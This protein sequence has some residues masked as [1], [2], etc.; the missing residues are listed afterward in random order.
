[1]F[2]P[3]DGVMIILCVVMLEIRPVFSWVSPGS[4]ILTRL[5]T[6]RSEWSSSVLSPLLVSR[7]LLVL[8]WMFWSLPSSLLSSLSFVLPC[9]SCAGTCSSVLFWLVLLSVSVALCVV[10]LLELFSVLCAR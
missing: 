7:S 10:C 5:P 4:M 6:C 9:S 1:M 3:C 8:W 2:W